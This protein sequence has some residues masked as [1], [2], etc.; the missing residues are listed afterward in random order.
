MNNQLQ[1]IEQMLEMTKT[2]HLASLQ[3]ENKQILNQITLSLLNKDNYTEDDKKMIFDI[4]MISNILY[5]NYSSDILVLEDGIYDLLM[6][7]CK[8]VCISFPV[9]GE[10]VNFSGKKIYDENTN[11]TVNYGYPIVALDDKKCDAMLF[12]RDIIPY[13][14]MDMRS[15]YIQNTDMYSDKNHKTK[16]TAHGYPELVGTLNKCK[17]VL[18]AQAAEKGVLNDENVKVF[19]RDFIAKQI[20]QGIINQNQILEMV[21]SLKYDG[22]SV[23]GDI[24]GDTL[25][26]ARSRG[27]TENDQAMDIT[28]ILYGYKFPF[29][30]VPELKDMKF[31]MKFE[32]IMT[33]ENLYNYN[34]AKQYNY[35]NCRTAITSIFNSIDGYMYRNLITLIPLQ[36]SLELS[37]LDEI[38]F[39]NKYYISPEQFRY[40]VIRGTYVEILFQVK[41]FVEEA[42]YL[43]SII[44]FMYDGV[45]AEYTDINLKNTLGRSN[46]VNQWAVAVKFNAMKKQTVFRGYSFTVGQNGII[47]PM[48]HYDPVEFFGTIHTKSTGHSYKR[49]MDLGL[50][51]NDIIDV[52]Y[53]NDVMPYV[54]KPQNN[55]N[56]SNQNIIVLFPTTC[57]SCGATIMISPS[58]K[59]ALCTNYNCP[60]RA[61]N[62]VAS[63]I[64]KLN[65][66][67][68]AEE[69]VKKIAMLYSSYSLKSI[70]SLT[71]EQLLV[72]GEVNAQKF[73]DN[74][75]ELLSKPVYDYKIMGSLGFEDI[76]E[77]KWKLILKNLTI[78]ELISISPE[79]LYNELN[80]IKGIGTETINTIM[81]ELPYYIEDIQFIANMKN[82][83]QSKGV[84]F[85]KIRFTGVRDID[86]VNQL[87]D[88]GYDA[89]E[90]SVTQDTNIL[91]VPNI[92]HNSSKVATAKKYGTMIIPINDLRQLINNGGTIISF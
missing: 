24:V 42:E 77:G 48:I 40:S 12:E 5:T 64:K 56:D 37:R 41:K 28:P 17:Y 90:G 72:L 13:T 84:T 36:T 63:M 18:N 32:A 14:Q 65:L 88:L 1:F 66:K 43:R 81:E 11:S 34:N 4:I 58:G 16:D 8:A 7:K 92:N 33:K 45:V 85:A 38:L 74:I 73:I 78:Q 59:S 60:E 79:N 2:G 21:L 61:I 69:S 87:N 53:T 15:Y 26:G 20:Q 19:E 25:Y 10:P 68:F 54:T 23:E 22:V 91:V 6:E 86:L 75:N 31:G 67:G 76:A 83:M 50:R 3:N 44:P 89:G 39:I 9:G 35:K 70:V 29:A 71:K 80:C 47:T 27:D 52:E 46:S 57:P 30:S 62:R 49:F 82:V 55:Y 51:V